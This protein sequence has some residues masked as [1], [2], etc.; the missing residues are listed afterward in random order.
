MDYFKIR[1]LVARKWDFDGKTAVNWFLLMLRKKNVRRTGVDVD[2]TNVSCK[3]N[4]TTI[5]IS[6]DVAN[7]SAT[8]FYFAD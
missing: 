8:F 3:F 1:S 5:M 6:R 7:K 4:S 2:R